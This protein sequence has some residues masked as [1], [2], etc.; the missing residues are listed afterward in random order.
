EV[1]GCMQTLERL[2]LA[3]SPAQV[4]PLGNQVSQGA[5][6]MAEGH[7]AVHTARGLPSDQ[8]GVSRVHHFAP[9]LKPKGDGSFRSK[10]SLTNI[11]KSSWISHG[12]PPESRTMPGRRRG[13]VPRAG[14]AL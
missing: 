9:V 14:H 4:I 5:S 6:L 3:A 1:I 11:E 8:L 13:R 10:L 2:A 7:S 12:S